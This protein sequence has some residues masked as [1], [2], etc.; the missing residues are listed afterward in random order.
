[1]NPHAMVRQCWAPFFLLVV[2]LAAAPG[3]GDRSA[4]QGGRSSGSEL[5]ARAAQEG[6]EASAAGPDANTA[7]DDGEPADSSLASQEA[8]VCSAM[9]GGGTRGPES[10]GVFEQEICGG[11]G[12]Q[13]DCRCPEGVCVCTCCGSQATQIRIDTCPACPTTAEAYALCGYP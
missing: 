5:D 12:Y 1:M 13:I 6:L 10:C 2:L 3:C 4:L 8:S 11:V 9:G 7:Q